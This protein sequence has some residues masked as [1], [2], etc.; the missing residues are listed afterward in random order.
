M[1]TDE[2]LQLFSSLFKGIKDFYARRWEKNG[3]SGYSPAYSF[4]WNEFMAFKAQEGTLNEFPNKKL[5]MLTLEVIRSHLEG[6]QTVGIY[7][8]LEDN[9]SHFIVADFDKE[10]WQEESKAFLNVCKEQKIP[11]YL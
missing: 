10:N 1:V 6:T 5:L 3:R 11:A 4:T 2:Q 7:P 9:T 8:L